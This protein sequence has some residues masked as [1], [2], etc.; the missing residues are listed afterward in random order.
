MKRYLNVC[1][2]ILTVLL[3]GSCSLEDDYY[4]LGDAWVG[5]G[6]LHKTGGS[7]S[8]VYIKLDDGNKLFA[9]ASD[10][11]LNQFEDSSRVLANF[12]ILDDKADSTNWKEY[13]VKINSMYDILMK[14]VIDITEA[15]KDSIGDD[16]IIVKNAWISQNLLTFELKYWGENAIHFINLV[17]QPGAL[18]ASSQP[19][20][21]ELR[22]NARDDGRII[23]FSGYVTF[24]LSAIK[25]NGMDSVRFKVKATDYEGIVYEDDGVFKYGQ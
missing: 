1:V 14:G 17:K 13:Y 3:A 12:T 18:S 15:N 16:P 9:V 19:I 20:E 23:P 11:N 5:F 24:D 8:Q 21:L 25:I 6:I 7:D 4:S 22:H 10:V 2:I